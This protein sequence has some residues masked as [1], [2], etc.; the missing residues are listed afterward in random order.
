MGTGAELLGSLGAKLRGC[1]MKTIYFFFLLAIAFAM[2]SVFLGAALRSES[3]M[4]TACR[5]L[6]TFGPDLEPLCNLP[7]PHFDI[8]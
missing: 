4:A 5:W 1:G 6:V 7:A 2:Y 8:T 3:I